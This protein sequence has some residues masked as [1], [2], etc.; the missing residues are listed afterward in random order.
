MALTPPGWYPD[1]TVPGRLRWWDGTAWTDRTHD[2]APA[3]A[4][5]A[6]PAMVTPPP[7]VTSPPMVTRP[8]TATP[9]EA[10]RRPGPGLGLSIGLLVA[11]VLIGVVGAVQ[12]GL[13]FFR[14]IASSDTMSIPG[15]AVFELEAGDY[16]VYEET[17]TRNTAGGFTFQQDDGVT[18]H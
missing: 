12:A 4:P 8:P 16:L 13:P 17:G 14:A 11:G 3:A 9:A 1:A 10:G 5:A 2:P 6:P 7:T 18:V 15:E